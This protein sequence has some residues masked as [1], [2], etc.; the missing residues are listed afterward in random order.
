MSDFIQS[1][2]KDEFKK[3]ADDAAK[4]AMTTI[5]LLAENYAR[6]ICPVDTGR[7]RNSITSVADSESTTIGTN[8]QYAPYVELGTSRQKAQPYLRPAIEDHL[9][10]YEDIIRNELRQG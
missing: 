4:V 9:S 6:I 8:V 3:A 10:E 5:G 7:L 1:D 2:N